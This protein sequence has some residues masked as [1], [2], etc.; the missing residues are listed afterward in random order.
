MASRRI[1]CQALLC[2]HGPFLLRLFGSTCDPEWTETRA[3]VFKNPTGC[4]RR[5]AS[6]NGPRPGRGCQYP[7]GCGRRGVSGLLLLREW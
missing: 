6:P 4:G 5:G 1:R 2:M 3:R 7:T